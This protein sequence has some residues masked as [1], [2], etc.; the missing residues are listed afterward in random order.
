MRR[1]RRPTHARSKVHNSCLQGRR[2]ARG[3]AHDR[4]PASKTF[5]SSAP[6]D[7]KRE[8]GAD[9]VIV[10]H[11][12]RRFRSGDVLHEWGV[13][14]MIPMERAELA[15]HAALEVVVATCSSNET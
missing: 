7:P 12:S 2:R 9:G 13:E 15:S 10:V 1:A 4:L 11:S 3:R 8:N 5:T 14:A 6:C